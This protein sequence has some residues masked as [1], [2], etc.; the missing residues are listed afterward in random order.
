MSLACLIL[1]AGKGARMNSKIPKVL[2]PILGIPLI[3][4]VLNT[5][6]SLSP[7]VITMVVG[8][9][10]DMLINELK[11]EK[12]KFIL[13]KK[14]L[15]TGHAVLSAKKFFKSF[16]G[17]ILI[18]NGDSP[19]I[20][21]KTLKTFLRGHIKTNSAVSLLTGVVENPKGYGRVIRDNLNKVE[22]II[23][24]K[25]CNSNQRIINEINS[26]A[27]IVSSE[28]LWKSVEKLNN[29][30]VQK[31]LYLPDII[32]VAYR[33]K[34][35]I[36]V[37]RLNNTN[38]ILGVNNRNELIYAEKTIKFEINNRH[39]IKG[40]TI[41]E[42]LTTFISPGVKIGT[43][44]IIYPNTYIYGESVIGKN[45][46]IGP[47]VW[48]KDSKI[49]H[50]VNVKMNCFIEEAIVKNRVQLGPF[51]NLRPGTF[52][53]DKAK[54]GNFVELKKSSVGIGSKVP[55]LSYIGDS[56]LG[57]NVNIGAGT[58]TCNYDGYNKNKTIIEDNVFIGSDTMLVAPIKIGKNATTGAGSTIT[59][60]VSEGSLAIERSKQVSIEN[61]K[62]TKK[63]N[64]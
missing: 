16:K 28:F 5:A 50:D 30:N 27:Y 55:H 1:S 15:G 44:T 19:L 25:D 26:G 3:K 6:Q 61:W 23:E 32:N 51:A 41:I 59:K 33:S 54:I 48:M 56:E 47:S 49:G 7:K 31:E 22:K 8:Y 43:D 13:Q 12:V 35:N 34:F 36:G 46:T 17:N 14:Q 24:E 45:C 2:H 37:K 38:E 63:N 62:R 57:K 52:I 10:Q 60:D 40:V 58:I 64:L 29:S 42:P 9:R 18:L 20:K 4:Y 21:I 39:M 53:N 11:G